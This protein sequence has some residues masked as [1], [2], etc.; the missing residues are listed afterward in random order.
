[1]GT[2]VQVEVYG[3]DEASRRAGIDEAFG[4][5]AE[6]DRLM[7]NYRDDSELSTV[8]HDAASAAVPISGPLLSVLQAAERV[9]VASGGAFDVTVGPAVRL[10]GIHDHQAHLPS[11]A[12]LAA[13]RPLVDYRNVV[14]DGAGRTVRFA[15]PGVEI[16]LGGIAKGFAVEVAANS[17]RKRGLSAFIDAG[18]NQFLLGLPPGKSSWAAGIRS[19]DG[20]SGLLGVV[21]TTETSVSTSGNYANFV[22]IA[23]RRVGHIIDPRTLQPSIASL[24][25]TVVSRDATLA[26]ALSKVA[27]VLGPSAGLAVVDSFP[28][29]GAVIAYRLP[30]GGTGVRVSK[31]LARRFHAVDARVRLDP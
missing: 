8:N 22:E 5:M 6:V 14:I 7:S 25:A 24:S 3:G 31:S 4:A 30:D 15:R 20:G 9:S 28:G 1:M 21:D 13:V 12:E 16:D 27:F 2:S 17:L 26:D 23:G 18:G 19:A 11:G 29:A 10:W